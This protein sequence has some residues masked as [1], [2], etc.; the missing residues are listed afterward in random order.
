MNSVPITVSFVA[1]GCPKNLVDSEKMLGLLLED[2][3]ALVGPDD[4]ADAV[5]IN[6][7]GFIES[8]RQE[9][10]EHIEMAIAAK[11]D[12]TVAKIIVAGCLAQYA[13]GKLQHSFPDVDAI[14]GL[15]DRGN[16]A[17]IVRRVV[18]T[19][20]LTSDKPPISAPDPRQRWRGPV[21]NDQTRLRLT[22]P[23][24]SYLRISEGCNQ[25]CAFC[26]IP[27]IRGP[28]RSKPLDAILAEA[29]ELVADGTVELNLIG[30]ETTNY[31]A[32]TGQ[33]TDLADLLRSLNEID[34]LRW[35]RLLY[36]HP[37]SLTNRHIAAMAQCDKVVPY[38]DL[39]LQHINDRILKL[40]NRHIDRAATEQLIAQLRDTIEHLSIRTTMLVGFPSETKAEFAELLD[41]VAE[42]RFEALGAFSYSLEENTAAGRMPEQLPDDVKADRLDKLMT[43][44]QQI[45]FEHARSLVGTI[46]P[47]LLTAELDDNTIV[48]LQLDPIGRWFSARHAGQAAEID[49]ECFLLTD[50]DTGLPQS[51]YH[52]G[53]ITP[54]KITAQLDYDLIGTITS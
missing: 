3:I 19:D 31:G 48:E 51:P 28:F 29:E 32:D 22:E 12:G 47:C 37:A 6:T 52:P 21:P 46:M 9:A 1:L 38:I 25:G 33:K 26:T 43:R 34:G 11:K 27:T 24:W 20:T 2:S 45:A 41:F 18:S 4:S 42:Q 54:A 36:A 40:M 53:T 14:V 39:P 23:F 30:Q 16:I 44:Q 35:I 49:S 10:F 13:G 17:A 50:D 15:A 8:A 7:C 5:I